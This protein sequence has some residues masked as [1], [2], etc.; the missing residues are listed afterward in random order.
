MGLLRNQKSEYFLTVEPF[1][2]I[3]APQ[4]WITRNMRP[5]GDEDGTT[6]L[7]RVIFRLV[8]SSFPLCRFCDKTVA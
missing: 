6:F 8:K 7:G 2:V 3:S 4:A 1:T 5:C